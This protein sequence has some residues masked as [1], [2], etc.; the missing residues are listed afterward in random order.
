MMPTTTNKTASLFL[1]NF[2]LS[3]GMIAGLEILTQVDNDSS[4]NITVSKDNVSGVDII[5]DEE[6][7]GS[8]SSFGPPP[9]WNDVEESVK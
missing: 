6:A 9:G 3:F 2:L 8:I 4:A 1:V 5:E 7:S